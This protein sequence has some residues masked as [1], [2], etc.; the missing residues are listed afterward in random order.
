MNPEKLEKIV[1]Y[2]NYITYVHDRWVEIIQKI[3]WLN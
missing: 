1:M 2:M 3:I